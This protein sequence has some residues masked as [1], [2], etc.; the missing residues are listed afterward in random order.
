MN[1]ENL[2][3]YV[4][5]VGPD[6]S[7][8]RKSSLEPNFPRT[9]PHWWSAAAAIGVLMAGAIA[10]TGAPLLSPPSPVV[11]PLER[12]EH[13]QSLADEVTW[14]DPSPHLL[15]DTRLSPPVVV[16]EIHSARSTP[17][18]RSRATL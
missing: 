9:R 7:T 18:R 16:P 15:A 3:T 13:V 14:Y 6:G 17:E 8:A 4:I 2:S 5:T 12:A 1:K 11:L 10:V